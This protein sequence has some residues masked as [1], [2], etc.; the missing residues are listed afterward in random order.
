MIPILFAVS[1]LASLVITPGVIRLAEHH[2]LY[3][4]PTGGRRVHTRPVPRLGGIPVFAATLLA[5]AVA[6]ATVGGGVLR[7]AEFQRFLRAVLLGG[8]ILFLVGLVDDLRGVSPRV[9]MGAQ[10][11]AGIVFWQAGLRLESLVFGPEMG[12]TMGWISLPLTVAWVVVVTNAFNLVDGLDGLASGIGLVA[13]ASV[14][15]TAVLLGRPE[16]LVVSV[17]L[18]GALL[19]F[20]RYNYRPARIFL[21]DSGSLLI[22]CM[23]AMLSVYGVSSGATAALSVT[24]LFA[25]AVPLMDTVLAVL[26]RWLRGV[27]FHAADRRHIHHQLL[28]RGL[29]HLRAVVVL[30]VVAF[31]VAVVGLLVAFA[32]R[33]ATNLAIGAGGL[34]SAVSFL[35]WSMGYLKYH[36]FTEALAVLAW[37][38]RRMRRVIQDRIHARDVAEVINVAQ[39]LR[40]VNAILADNASN[41]GFLEMAVCLEGDAHRRPIVIENGAIL[42][43]P[44]LE[45]PVSAAEPGGEAMYVLRIWCHPDL[46][47]PHG[48]ERVAGIL[49]PTIRGWLAQRALAAPAPEERVA[50]LAAERAIGVAPQG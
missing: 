38:P 19:G 18:L 47:R 44:K 23:L 27:P 29:T 2:G 14:V 24:P 15:A 46:S 34:L 4:Q 43:P 31:S 42:H 20:L 50:S 9:K 10:A 11:V 40:E 32:P 36:E 39:T 3:D 16:V 45:F 8:G 5:L 48:V 6:E 17:A 22:G 37:G 26:R 13:L 1:I 7:E 33:T 35:L 41:F 25:L 12:A 21:G 49:A 28:A 30:H